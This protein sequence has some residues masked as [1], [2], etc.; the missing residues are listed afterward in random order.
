MKNPIQTFDKIKENLILYIK[1]AFRTRYP[2]FEEERKKLLNQDKILA[3]SPWVE[4][5]PKYKGSGYKVVNTE[6]NVNNKGLKEITKIP[7]LNDDE[8][9]TFKDVVSK[10]LVGDYELHHHQYEMLTKAM[11]GNHSVITSGTGDR[12][13]VV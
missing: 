7:N 4:P 5:L 12:K 13:S 6:A 10:G 2:D 1:T 8:L 9:K 11:E 3:R